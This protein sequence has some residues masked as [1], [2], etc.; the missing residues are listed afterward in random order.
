MPVDALAGAQPPSAVQQLSQMFPDLEHDILAA[1]LDSVGHDVERAVLTLVDAAADTQQADDERVVRQLQEQL[2]ED[3]ARA[4]H[5]SLQQ[6]L[7][8]EAE[9]RRKE[10]AA[11]AVKTVGNASAG[12]RSLLQSAMRKGTNAGRSSLNP[13]VGSTTSTH[14]VRLL[15]APLESS[16]YDMSPLAAE[17][18]PPT[19]MPEVR[20]ASPPD[21]SDDADGEDTSR[22]STARYSS[23]MERAREANRQRRVTAPGD[24]AAGLEP[25]RAPAVGVP[26]GEL[27]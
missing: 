5:A 27:I 19:V 20:P 4:V 6:E 2:D 10:V 9:Q 26:E 25:L 13:L 1:V 22:T 8:A 21:V 14:E 3:V 12:L 11:K 17:Y 15:D 18:T 23:R 7:K 24:A 16:T